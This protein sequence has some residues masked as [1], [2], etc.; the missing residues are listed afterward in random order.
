MF[1]EFSSF[2]LDSCVT[3]CF[4]LLKPA[5]FYEQMVLAY[6]SKPQQSCMGGSSEKQFS[7]DDTFLWG[8]CI[9]LRK[10]RRFSVKCATYMVWLVCLIV[11]LNFSMVQ[12]DLTGWKMSFFLQYYCK[13]QIFI[14]SQY[15]NF[16]MPLW[17]WTLF[18]TLDALQLGVLFLPFSGNH[19]C[20]F[21]CT[22]NGNHSEVKSRVPFI[23][24]SFS[25]LLMLL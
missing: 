20:E 12:W 19:C 18:R 21:S 5:L 9:Q 10:F 4:W 14:Q 3:A 6:F 11:S 24:S 8:I 15:F 25:T 16:F 2:L 17:N 13:L 22:Y 1:F 7:I 23:Y